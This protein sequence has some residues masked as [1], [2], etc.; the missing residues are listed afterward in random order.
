M[1]EFEYDIDPRQPIRPEQE[2]EQE[3]EGRRRRFPPE[4]KEELSP[5]KPIRRPLIDPLFTISQAIE[6]A[7]EGGGHGYR[8]PSPPPP[9]PPPKPSPEDLRKIRDVAMRIVQGDI[10]LDEISEFNERFG[11]E[12]TTMVQRT[13]SF[14]NSP[15]LRRLQESNRYYDSSPARIVRDGD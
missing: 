8:H 14:Y 13:I 11:S 1:P 6:Q 9:G 15:A 4:S 5:A 7:Q 3:Q 10:N 2:P 12:L